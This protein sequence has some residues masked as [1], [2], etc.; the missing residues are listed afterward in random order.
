MINHDQVFDTVIRYVTFSILYILLIAII[1]G[2]LNLIYNVGYITYEILGGN[3]IHISF[4]DVVVGVLTIF[5]LIDLFKTFVDY[6]EHKRIRLVYITDATIL[7]VMREIAVGV[8][9][10]RI[11]YEFILSLSILLLVLGIIRL[12]SVKYPNTDGKNN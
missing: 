10:S 2:L 6:R 11:E 1:V 12:L 9:V 3:F 7:I 4:I 8:Y 5:I